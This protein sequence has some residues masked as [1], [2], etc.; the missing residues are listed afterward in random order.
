MLALARRSRAGVCVMHM[1]GTP[2]TMQDDPVYE[3][4]VGEI[5]AWLA[6]RRDELVAAGID[7][8]RICLDPGIGFGK[9]N[10]HNIALMT[11]CWRLHDL[12]CPLLVGHSRKAFIGKLIGDKEADRTAGTVGGALALAHQ[13]VQIIRVHDVA[14]VRQA[15]LV[16][17][18]CGGI[19]IHG[20]T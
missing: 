14:P 8:Q 10:T 5:H 17:A 15:L 16:F 4:V 7:R 11:N 20:Q 3:D 2:Q 18:A 12:R 13:A 6:A 1:R 9:T 19:A